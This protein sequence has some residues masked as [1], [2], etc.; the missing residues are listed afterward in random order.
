[1][2]G[3]VEV[4]APSRLGGGFRWLL[5]SSW[6][7]NLGDGLALAAAPLLVASVSRDPLIIS[8]AALLQRL[9]WL[10]FGLV[11]GVLA[12]RVDRR[13][14][15]VTVNAIRAAALAGLAVAIVGDRVGVIVVLAALFALATAEVFV[16][17]SASALLPMMVQSDDLG[18]ANARL[19]FGAV[20]LNQLAGPA[21]GAFLFTVGTAVP[22]AAQAMIMTVGALFALRV[23]LPKP[24]GAEAVDAQSR[25]AGG[26]DRARQDIAEGIHWLRH[27][28]AVRTLALIILAFNITFGIALS[29]L[30]LLAIERLGLG[31][32][33]F[34][35]LTSAAAAGGIV[36][37]MIYGVAERAIGVVAIMRIGLTIE[38]LTH[39]VL[40][41]T[42]TAWVALATF[43]IAG[44]HVSMWGTTSTSIRQ[45]AVPLALQ[46]RVGSVY[47]LGA[48]SGHAIGAILGGAIAAIAGLTAAYWFSF[49]A[50]AAI[51]ALIWPSLTNIAA[52]ADT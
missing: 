30:V 52:T 11:A 1:M 50:T 34:G 20:S 36:G 32:I 48:H 39:L 19:I 49:A 38:T 27:H 45:R 18:I 44:I 4:I 14:I 17:T 42:T 7:T 25:P 2:P 9:P 13:L 24:I 23:S 5:G 22:F 10:L 37:T 33:G 6:A 28:P 26:L 29:L 31:E 15:V 41:T 40:A 46:G 35:L 3:L 21:L 12:D 51:L 16:D 43:F 47:M 8:P